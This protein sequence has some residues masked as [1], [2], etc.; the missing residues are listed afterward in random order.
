MAQVEV[1]K[2]SEGTVNRR[3]NIIGSGVTFDRKRVAAYVRVSTDGEEQLQSFHSQKSYYEEKN[4]LALHFPQPKI[5]I[6]QNSL[7]LVRLFPSNH[8]QY[9]TTPSLLFVNPQLDR[10]SLLSLLRRLCRCTPTHRY[11][12]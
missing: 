4:S 10:T 9:Q 7:P 2:A 6:L 5:L 8:K 3:R 12:R 1:I 11:R